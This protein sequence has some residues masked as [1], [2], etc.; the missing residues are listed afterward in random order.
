MGI[1][2][3]STPIEAPKNPDTDHVF[4]LYKLIATE[5][6]TAAM[7]LNYEGGNYSRFV[8]ILLF[9]HIKVFSLTFF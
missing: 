1:Q 5:E 2:T 7:R 9:F 8:S 4:A 3:D 6:Q